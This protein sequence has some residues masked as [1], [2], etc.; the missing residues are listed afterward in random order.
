MAEGQGQPTESPATAPPDKLSAS[1]QVYTTLKQEIMWG[2]IEPG[3]LLSEQKLAGRFGV[4]RTPVREALTMLASDGLTTTLSRRGHLV[5][6]VSFSEILG[7]FRLRELLE[8][9]AAGQAANRITDQDLADLKQLAEIRNGTDMLA[10]DREFHMTIARASG[11]RLLAEF[12]ERLLIL[13]QSVLIKDPH[14]KTYTEDG[15]QVQ[16]TIIDALASHDEEAAREAM[17]CHIRN[18]L[19]TILKELNAPCDFVS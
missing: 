4:S 11:N 6:T 12:I 1:E 5:R 18:T 10:D 2:E 3:T 7:A 9:E 13:M 16:L 19:T 8:V 17:G 15:Y 14:F